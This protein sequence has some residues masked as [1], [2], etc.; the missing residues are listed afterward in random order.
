MR[1]CF[2][3]SSVSPFLY[4]GCS[5]PFEFISLHSIPV[6]RAAR[7]LIRMPCSSFVSEKS[8]H[9]LSLMNH[10]AWISGNQELYALTNS[11]MVKAECEFRTI[12]RP[13]GDS[14][15]WSTCNHGRKEQPGWV[16]SIKQVCT[17]QFVLVKRKHYYGIGEQNSFLSRKEHCSGIWNIPVFTSLLLLTT[18]PL[19]HLYIR[20]C[21]RKIIQITAINSSNSKDSSCNGG[22][23]GY[24][25]DLTQAQLF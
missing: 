16:T 17:W 21:C 11:D 10:Q 6:I 23:W 9:I 15:K 8:C 5:A 14:S 2:R 18:S 25:N 24:G 1:Q 20:Y 4:H 7:L 13:G 19:I 3:L 12:Q 22:I